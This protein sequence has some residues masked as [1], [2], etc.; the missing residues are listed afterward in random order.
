MGHFLWD[1]PYE[2]ISPTDGSDFCALVAL[3]S[4]AFDAYL[5][6]WLA[7]EGLC[8]GRKHGYLGVKNLEPTRKLA[9]SRSTIHPNRARGTISTARSGE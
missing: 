3:F 2:L 8:G 7:F 4:R 9:Q 1:G 5:A 6:L